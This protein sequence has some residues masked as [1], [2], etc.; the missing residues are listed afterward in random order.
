[1]EKVLGRIETKKKALDRYRPFPVAFQENIEDWLRIELTY[2]SNAI[3]GNTLSRIETMLIVEKGIT[4]KGKSLVEHQE[5]INHARAFDYVEDL[6][7]RKENV[8]AKEVVLAI[9][10]LILDRINDPYK[11]R[12]RD[13]PVRI[14]GSQA[15]LPNPLKVPGLMDRLFQD[16]DSLKVD[17]APRKAVGVHYEFVRIHPFVDGNGRTAR[18]LMNY[19]LLKSD[20][21]P[22][23]IKKEERATYIGALEEYHVLG[24]PEKYY[25][26]MYKT[27]ERGLDEYLQLLTKP[28]AEP[29]RKLLKIGQLASRS[30]VSIPTVRYW[31]KEGLLVIQ[32]YT[33]GGYQLYAESM[34]ERVRQIHQLQEEGL[35]L[36]SIKLKL[37]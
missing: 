23:L 17:M 29:G 31:T 22:A 24:R 1:M 18:L 25:A 2:N 5:A 6:I 30:G 33:K 9:H 34:I 16:I 15:V 35:S 37:L 11:G 13:V 32:D 21:A 3:E 14:S 20:Y 7:K 26:Y 12:F 19:L 10:S 4:A 8:P 36:Q 27:I 28:K